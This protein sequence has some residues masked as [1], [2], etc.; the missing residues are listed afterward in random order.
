M[1][2]A[3]DQFGSKSPRR[4]HKQTVY[5]TNNNNNRG[6]WHVEVGVD[7]MDGSYLNKHPTMMYSA[8]EKKKKNPQAIKT[9]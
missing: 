3:L 7:T 2:V 4:I 8:I 5:K 1:K 6:K 9:P